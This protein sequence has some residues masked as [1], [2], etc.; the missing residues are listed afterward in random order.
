LAQACQQA[1]DA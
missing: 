1:L